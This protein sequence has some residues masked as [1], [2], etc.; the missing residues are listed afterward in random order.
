MRT[1]NIET[2][3]TRPGEAPQQLS[4]II[5]NDDG[6]VQY[7]DDMARDMVEGLRISLRPGED[8]TR[9]SANEVIDLLAQGWSNGYI[10]IAR[11]G[12]RA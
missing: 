9:I 3:P 10:R 12:V 8:G 6:S 1:L 4:Q 7:G 2:V 11:E 5:E